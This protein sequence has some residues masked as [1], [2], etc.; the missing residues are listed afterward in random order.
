MNKTTT[1]VD[2]AQKLVLIGMSPSSSS[3]YVQYNAADTICPLMLSK[4][5]PDAV[6]FGLQH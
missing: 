5:A 2:L 6:I 4:L 1:Q 3:I